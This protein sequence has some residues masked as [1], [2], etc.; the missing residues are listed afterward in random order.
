[1]QKIFRN[2]DMDGACAPYDWEELKTLASRF[3][4]LD[5]PHRWK[6]GCTDLGR[7]TLRAREALKDGGKIDL[8]NRPPSLTV[9]FA[10][11]QAQRHLDTA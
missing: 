4:K 5:F 9:V 11:N 10:E 7:W 6:N 2:D 8:R 1:M 3:E